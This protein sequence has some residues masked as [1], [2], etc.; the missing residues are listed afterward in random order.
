MYGPG[1][2]TPGTQVSV[3]FENDYRGAVNVPAD[4]VVKLS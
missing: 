3:Q 2:D 4:R 1:T